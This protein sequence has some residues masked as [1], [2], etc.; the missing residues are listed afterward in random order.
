MTLKRVF[1][2]LG[3]RIRVFPA[4]DNKGTAPATVAT[5]ELQLYVGNGGAVLALTE[6]EASL[7]LRNGNGFKVQPADLDPKPEPDPE[8]PAPR[9]LPDGYQ[10]A[11]G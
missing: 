11:N 10:Q 1:G 3:D 5:E 7:L 4:I 6:E 2:V 9:Q 8:S